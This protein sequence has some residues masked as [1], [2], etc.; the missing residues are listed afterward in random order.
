STVNMNLEEAVQRLRGKAGSK[1]TVWVKRKKWTEPKRFVLTRAII[2]IQSVTSELLA[3]AVGYIKIKSF[4]ANTFDD[5]HAHLEQLRASNRGALKGLILDLRNN[6]G[7]LLDQAILI[8]DRFVERGPL[9]ITVGE[10][11]RRREVKPAH[12]PGTETDYPLAVL[13]NG[14]SASASEIVSGAVKNHNR[15][16]IIGEQTFGKGSVQVLYDFKDRSAL[17]LTIAQYLTPGDI[18][19]QSKGITPDIE[20]AHA[21]VEEKNLHLFV[22]DSSPREKDLDRHLDNPEAVQSGAGVDAAIAGKEPVKLVRLDEPVDE[23]AA[24][25]QNATDE[26]RSDYEIELAHDLLKNARSTDRRKILEQARG[27]IK[28]TAVD[29]QRRIAAKLKDFGVD[30]SEGKKAGTGSATVRLESN[31]KGT[32]ATIRAGE[33]LSFTA[34]VTNTG[35]APLYRVYGVTESENPLLRNQELVF[36]KVDP[37]QSRSWN[38]EIKLPQDMSSRADLMSLTVRDMNNSLEDVASDLVV[39]IEEE[40]KPR[41]SFRAVV[42]DRKGGNGDGVLQF[43]ETVTLDVTVENDGTG[44]AQ[45]T[46]ATLKNLSHGLVFLDRG[47]S[48]IGEIAPGKSASTELSFAIKRP[49]RKRNLLGEEIDTSKASMRLSIWD[50][51][52]GEAIT[53]TLEIPVVD[54]RPVKRERRSVKVPAGAQVGVYAG[55]DDRTRVIAT[56]GAGV[57]LRSDAVVS[58]AGWRR[59]ELNKNEFGFVRQ[60][61]VKM[62]QGNRKPGAVTL[63]SGY[64]APS[65]DLDLDG[66]V[67]ASPTLQLTG[68][69]K[70]DEQ[71]QDVF[72]FLNDKKIFYKSFNDK[73]GSGAVKESLNLALKLKEGSNSVAV[74]A[75]KND[76]LVSRRIFG[77]YRGTPGAIAERTVPGKRPGDTATR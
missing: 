42:D 55:A 8:S 17:K 54:A 26:F 22:H 25:V 4:Q 61:E 40:A 64:A 43:G 14:G 58:G 5:L 62:L 9:V 69:I 50:S 53:E 24:A 71:V 2:K 51:V 41:F 21:T 7:G 49:A 77:L 30:W 27:L 57:V 15:G 12:A 31:L 63:S 23:E 35:S 73:A 32:G 18:S 45:E 29:E 52:L 13:V 66:L 34:T 59:V 47:R 19:I 28:R 10:G 11:N 44:K 65:I 16:V 3:D 74:V 70:D 72:V 56:A 39:S 20:V 75:R 38:V 76:D 6:P 48:K 33:L 36:G 60:A 68:V 46:S 1:V 37:G 67:T